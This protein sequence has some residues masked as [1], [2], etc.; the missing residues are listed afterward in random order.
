MSF[1]KNFLC[2]SIL[3]GVLLTHNSFCQPV[4]TIRYEKT[5]KFSDEDFTVVPLQEDGIALLHGTN[6]YKSR[7]RTWELILIDTLLQ[8]KK[9]IEF[10]I[11]NRSRLVGYEHSP[12][13]LYALYISNEVTGEMVLATIQLQ[14]NEVKQYEIKPELNFRL[15]HFNKVGDNFIFGGF[16]NTEPCVLLY[17]TKNDNLKLVPGFFQKQTELIDVR[18]NQNETFNTLIVDRSNLDNRKIIFKTFDASGNLLLED[19]TEAGANV[20]IQ[21]GI[22][23]SLQREDLLIVGTWGKKNSKSA[24]G[25]YS[26]TIDP[27]SE[28][29]LNP[30]YFGELNH[31]LD[32]LKPKR[33][34]AIK[35]KTK[36]ALDK[37]KI[38]DFNSSIMPYKI[39]EHSK[40]FLLLAE[41]YTPTSNNNQ[42]NYGYS[43]YSPYSNYPYNNPYGMYSP[44]YYNRRFIP[45]A[46]GNNVATEEDH[47]K[48]EAI[49]INMDGLGNVQW[50]FSLEFNDL[51]TETLKQVSEVF[52]ESDSLHILYKVQSQLKVKTISLETEESK[53]SVQELKLL[54]PTD[55]IQSEEKQ[56]EQ[57]ECWYRNVFFV[58]GYQTIY[59]KTNEDRTRHVFY[60]IKIIIQ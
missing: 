26:L 20:T 3:I 33:A 19:V 32:Y 36:A 55:K 7:N 11:E 52:L 49:A 34:S 2:F 12:D 27:F 46:Y 13:W 29:K 51:K 45:P 39:I 42:Y 37:N 38:P 28:G 30:I 14:T 4:Q 59:N 60:I 9:T 15:T 41:S 16:V 25:F 50:D 53:E 35:L 17:Y 22:S 5:F 58:N 6:K 40:G 18:V 57:V 47:K 23:S 21:T 24:S 43:P 31:F 44:Y 48:I 54:S 1:N 56:F 8:E 10:E